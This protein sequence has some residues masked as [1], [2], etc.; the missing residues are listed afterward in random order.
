MSHATITVHSSVEALTMDARGQGLG[1]AL[2]LASLWA[3]AEE[4]YGY[5]IIGGAVGS[6]EFYRKCCGATPIA[7]SEPGVYGSLYR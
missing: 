1:R 6:E 5:A 7:G 2:L 4:G 3:M